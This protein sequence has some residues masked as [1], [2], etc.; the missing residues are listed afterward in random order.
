MCLLWGTNW[1]FISQK[2]AFFI[3]TTLRTSNLKQNRPLY[4]LFYK[5]FTVWNNI[6]PPHFSYNISVCLSVCLSVMNSR[7][8]FPISATIS[9]WTDIQSTYLVT[10]IQINKE[11]QFNM[12][13]MDSACLHPYLVLPKRQTEFYLIISCTCQKGLYLITWFRSLT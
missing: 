3:V 12:S 13:F 10:H 4:S 8:R 11:R 1:V 7:W 9:R 5:N 2:R 6:Q